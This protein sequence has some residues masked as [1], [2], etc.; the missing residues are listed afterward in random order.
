MP[1]L[2]APAN[3]ALTTDYTPRLD[4]KNSLPAADHYQLQVAT[5]S[6]FTALVI[7]RSDVTLS[8]F[9]PASNLAPN[10]RY[11]WRVSGYNSLGQ[12]SAWSKV[13]SFRTVMLPP[14]LLTPANGGTAGRKPVFD[15]Q[16]VVGATGYTIQISTSPRFGTFLVNKTATPST[17]TPGTKLPVGTVYWRV[18][19]NGPNGPSAWSAT[20]SVTITP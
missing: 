18:R 14:V 20:W 8:E 3:N 6:A 11:Y 19:A 9:T 17:F 4:W 5:D 13:R 7:N 2:V 12:Y 10:T 15:W 1:V 16:D